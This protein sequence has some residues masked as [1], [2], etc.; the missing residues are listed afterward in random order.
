MQSSRTQGVSKNSVSHWSSSL[1][2][3]LTHCTSNSEFK[4]VS[5]P[6]RLAR[7]LQVVC[8]WYYIILAANAVFAG[9]LVCMGTGRT[10]D[11]FD[12]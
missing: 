12:T 10:V 9:A 3:P 11:T 4:N 6:R 8:V 2:V 1:I 5:K 7:N